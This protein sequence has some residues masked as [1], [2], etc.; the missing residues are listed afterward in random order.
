ME[1]EWWEGEHALLDCDLC[2]AK[3]RSPIRGLGQGDGGEA[4]ERGASGCS[5]GERS[6]IEGGTI[7]AADHRIA[8][9]IQKAG[10]RRE[11]IG[12]QSPLVAEGPAGVGRYRPAVEA[13]TAAGA[14]ARREEGAHKAA[15]IVETDDGI[16]VT[17]R[18]ALLA[19]RAPC[20]A[21]DEV[22]GL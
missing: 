4:E 18:D 9:E 8:E 21:G 15:G 1:G 13:K 12:E 11:G 5:R 22:L 2:P 10:S 19:L 17:P 3:A 20:Q 7:G 16:S 6:I 14:G